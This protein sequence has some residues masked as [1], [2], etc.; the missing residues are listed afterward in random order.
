M[1]CINKT[2]II[3]SENSYKSTPDENSRHNMNKSNSLR[4]AD[5][6]NKNNNNNNDNNN[7]NNYNN[8]S[9]SN[10][11]SNDNTNN[12]RNKDNTLNSLASND[13]FNN[14]YIIIGEINNQQKVGEFK[15]QLKSDPSEFRC[16]RKLKKISLEKNNID[17]EDSFILEQINLLKKIQ[18]K[19]ISKLYECITT[20]SCYFLIMDY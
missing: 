6:N 20:P 16:M 5:N 14:K 13:Y 18:H 3:K 11:T 8:I 15:I 2:E 9:S 12:N 4:N 19:H 7:N 17:A 1:G 10:I